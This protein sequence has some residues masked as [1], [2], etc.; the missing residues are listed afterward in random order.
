MQIAKLN[1]RQSELQYIPSLDGLR[2]VAILL[3]LAAHAKIGIPMIDSGGGL[4][5][6]IFFVLSGYLITRILLNE[7]NRKKSINFGAFYKK[8]LIRLWPALIAVISLMYIPGMI[9]FNTP[10]VFSLSSLFALFSLTP[11]TS[12]LLQVKGVY[13]YTWTLGLEEYFYLIF[14]VVLLFLFRKNFTRTSIVMMLTVGSTAMLA[15]MALAR[16][17]ANNPYGLFDLFSVAGIGLGCALA[18]ALENRKQLASGNLFAALGFLLIFFSLFLSILSPLSGLSHLVADLGTLSVILAST[19][20]NRGWLTGLLA[21][22]ILIFIGVISYEIYLWHA[23]LLSLVQS[24]FSLATPL[25]A[26]IAYPLTIALA[27][28]TKLML[29]PIQTVL[30]TRIRPSPENNEG[31]RRRRS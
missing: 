4:G 20:V 9:V 11:I 1:S 28:A 19:A 6:D 5:V 15:T 26:S 13:G 3:V 2:A 7:L 25:A 16:F 27:V 24:I 8:R 29:E 22:K 21:A 23:V 10:V 18:V 14:P 12:G 17:Q 31:G 30:R